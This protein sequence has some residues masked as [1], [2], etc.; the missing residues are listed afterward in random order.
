M[1]M[2]LKTSVSVLLANSEGMEKPP[3]ILSRQEAELLI[4]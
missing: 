1:L 4:F 3:G 2:L